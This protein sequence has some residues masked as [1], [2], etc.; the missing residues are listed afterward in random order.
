M[1]SMTDKE[2]KIVVGALLHDI[3]KVIYRQGDDKR[4]HSTSGH[5]FLKEEAGI[6]EQDVL[7]AVCYHHAQELKAAGIDKNSLAYI[8]YI[9]DNIAASTDRRGN[10]SEDYGFEESMPLQPVFNILNGNRQSKYYAPKM[11]FDEDGINYPIDTPKPFDESFYSKVKDR[12]L[13]NLRG[14]EWTQDY[15]NSLLEVL[16]G[17]LTY[18]PSST[19]KN[20]L[21]DISLFDHVKITAAVASCIH[22]YLEERGASSFREELFDKAEAFYSENAFILYSMDMS[23]IQNFIYTIAS[24]KAAKT[25]KARSFYL[26]IMMENI[27]DNLLDKLS[28]S[29]ANLIYSGG[30]HCYMLLANTTE[31]RRIIKEYNDSINKWF[32]DKYN[33]AL[34]VADGFAE[35]SAD[36][37][38]NEPNGSYSDIYKSISKMISAKKANRYTAEDIIKMN[39]RKASDYG[40]ECIV[41]KC[42]G[43]V[44]ADGVCK[45]CEA[46]ERFAVQIKKGEFFTV[47]F[48][49]SEASLPLPSDMFLKA[50]S[51][52]SL[53]KQIEEDSY[54]VRTYGKNRMFTGK[55]L[56]THLWV[57]DYAN[58]GTFEEMSSLSN[59]IERLGI[60]R[61]DVDNLGQ[62]FV[63]GFDN[64]NNDNRYVTI[65]RTATFSRQMSFF[66]KHHI[67]DILRN[68][69]YLFRDSNTGPRNVAIIYSGGDDLF[70]V[71]A[72]DDAIAAA[73]DI[74]KDFER[75]CQ[76]T[77]SISAGIGIYP[78]GYPIR[79]IA[80]EVAELEEK[81]KAYP[82][83]NAVTIF[84]DGE[85]H[86]VKDNNR[87]FEV[88]DGTYQWNELIEEV[89]GEKYEEIDRF[90]SNAQ[91]YGK[92]F[93][94]NILELVRGQSDKI[95]FA[96]FVYLISRMEP[97][98]KASDE[99]KANYTDFSKKMCD[100]IRSP[101]DCRQLKTAI[102]LYAYLVRERQDND[103][104]N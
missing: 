43:D 104:N 61:A 40:R 6:S 103:E 13:D 54:F 101:K 32:I 37:L 102:N 51:E 46:M 81:S 97:G 78:S 85:T 47:S 12:I 27:I 77:L 16:E 45:T 88:S 99:E 8:T 63:S 17:T 84:E 2:V 71:G 18:V 53:R 36:S 69:E 9:A 11:L 100:W 23:G 29:R 28:L 62:A 35:C 21:A 38:K 76:G 60:I 90:L 68:P 4:R 49:E 44:N 94:Y 58:G 66:F 80:S 10:D 39:G 59:G 72:W 5:D 19:S 65:S 48:K 64:P 75:F 15:V 31:T 92:N 52:E 73:I 95:N 93:L 57:G 50:D 98:E 7:E 86:V 41:C 42:V 96:R 82:G 14:L 67:N 24:K 22:R 20:E 26:E 25:L 30:G 83:K 70:I 1:L 34:F 74:K 55:R 87:A 56:S 79:A 89:I 91:D 33:V 3:G